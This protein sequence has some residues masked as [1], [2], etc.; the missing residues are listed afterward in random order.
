MDKLLEKDDLESWE[1]ISF[2]VIELNVKRWYWRKMSF[3]KY[4]YNSIYNT[5]YIELNVNSGWNI[6]KGWFRKLILGKNKF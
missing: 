6:R 5:I 3:N 1:R 2:N 4:M